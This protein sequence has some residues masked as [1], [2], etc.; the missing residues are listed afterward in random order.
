[1]LVKLK[2]AMATWPTQRVWLETLVLWLI[3][4]GVALP[5]ALHYQYVDAPMSFR[6]WLP[7]TLIACVPGLLEEIV[8]RGLLIPA[9]GSKHFWPMG[10]LSLT[11][12][13]VSHPI[14]AWIFRPTARDIFYSPAFLF[15][16]AS[17][18]LICLFIYA[19]SKSLWPCIL[20]HWFTV[21]VWL[22]FGGRTLLET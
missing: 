6:N 8:W 12:F 1:M 17:L 13:V 2:K 20:I 22:L 15:L 5:V 7:M 4:A 14:S 19:R 9:P 11:G 18:G 3:F 21:A 10:L 16:A